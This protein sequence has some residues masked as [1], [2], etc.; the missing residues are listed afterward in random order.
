MQRDDNLYDGLDT[1]DS[2]ELAEMKQTL[3]KWISNFKQRAE[4]LSTT[5]TILISMQRDA[6]VKIDDA[7]SS[8]SSSESDEDLCSPE[9]QKELAD[10]HQRVRDESS[11]LETEAK[12]L[13][14]G[15]TQEEFDKYL[16]S[17]K[18]KK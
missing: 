14:Q 4:E 13:F 2:E 8:S 11:Q 3:S 17:I 6:E 15:V 7:L 10:K 18:F 5:R 12:E 1:S 16:H 9:A